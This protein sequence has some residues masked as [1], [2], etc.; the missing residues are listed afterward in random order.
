MVQQKINQLGVRD[1]HLM[2]SPHG[3]SAGW[4]PPAF[5]QEIDMNSIS[6]QQIDNGSLLS[7]TL[8]KSLKTAANKPLFK[9]RTLDASV[10]NNYR[11]V[12]DHPF[13]AKVIENL[14]L[15]NSANFLTQVILLTNFNQASNLPT[16]LKQLLKK[17]VT[18]YDMHRVNY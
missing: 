15:I 16:V 4:V 6:M 8:P 14:F 9:T 5:N 17:G 12:P 13:I 18:I 3:G 11:A 10:F 2:N 1:V 7:A